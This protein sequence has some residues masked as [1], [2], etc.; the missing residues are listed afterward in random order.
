MTAVSQVSIVRA[1][2]IHDCQAFD[3]FDLRT[4]LCDVD[5]T[6]VEVSGLTR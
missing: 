5:D 2:L 1:I 3:P 6:C 4:G